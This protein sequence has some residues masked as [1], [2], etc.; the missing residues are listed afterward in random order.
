MRPLKYSQ[1]RRRLRLI[2]AECERSA[3]QLES[4]A[5]ALVS[6]AESVAVR[7]D[8]EAFRRRLFVE[9]RGKIQTRLR[10]EHPFAD[11]LTVVMDRPFLSIG[12]DPACDLILDHEEIAPRHSFLQWVDGHIFCCHL[13]PRSNRDSSKLQPNGCWLND[14]PISIGPFQLRLDRPKS[15]Q[16]PEY[17]PLDRSPNLMQDFPQFALQFQ[18]VEQ[19]DNQWPVNRV[20]TMVG[21]GSQCKLRLN[22]PSMP[23]VQACLMRTKSGCWL[24]DVQGEGTTGVNDRSV[25][26]APIDI[27]DV[28]RLGPFQVEVVTTVFDPV[29]FEV[30]KK[31]KAPSASRNS[32]RQESPN[33]STSTSGNSLSVVREAPSVVL[34]S[35]QSKPSSVPGDEI[36]VEA[37]VPDVRT[38]ADVYPLNK[39]PKQAASLESMDSIIG[40]ATSESVSESPRSTISEPVS[41]MVAASELVAVAPVLSATNKRQQFLQ[42]FTQSQQ[43]Q[44]AKLKTQLGQLKQQYD[45]VSVRSLSKRVRRRLDRSVNDALK[46]QDSMTESLGKLIAILEI[47]KT[48]SD[49]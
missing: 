32:Q 37:S 39:S 47:D 26:I 41:A 3:Q 2:K 12:S 7:M 21:R 40:L 38:I 11:P 15:S 22:H 35:P 24:I 44:L 6:S 17:S 30:S 28:L 18:G 8:A 27:G 25:T 43:S 13:A 45:M 10:I 33:N 29:D 49:S 34:E 19:K 16:D 5:S 4:A 14:Q 42:E 36:R 48:N 20:L 46:T 1:R 23:I 9:C 31:T